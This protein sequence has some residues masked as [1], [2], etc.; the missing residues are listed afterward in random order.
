MVVWNAGL[1]QPGEQGE[2]NS[3]LF[4]RLLINETMIKCLK[5]ILKIA[6]NKKYTL[7]TNPVPPSSYFMIDIIAKKT[8]SLVRLQCAYGMI[9]NVAGNRFLGL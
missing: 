1:D 2:G 3:A 8:V 9:R 7:L 4:L 5:I 6:I